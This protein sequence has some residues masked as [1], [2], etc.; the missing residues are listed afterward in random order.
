MKNLWK[1]LSVAIAAMSL[2][3]ACS[4]SNNSSIPTPAIPKRGVTRN[5][6]EKTQ[7]ASYIDWQ[8]YA[9]DDFYRYATGAWQDATDLGDRRSKGTQQKQDNAENEFP[10]KVCE[11]GCPLL[12]KLFTQ[13]KGAEDNNADRKKV[14]DKLADI[15][16]SVTTR[17]Q[18]WQK[19]AQLMK[20]GYAMPFDYC[21]ASN[22]RKI[23]P[24]LRAN[25]TVILAGENDLKQFASPEQTDL[26]VMPTSI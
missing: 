2:I 15:T 8:T 22:G 16:S 10:K 9:G 13:Y 12:Q 11:G 26:L 5:I 14:K 23:Y 21:A 3:A 19:I 1:N 20:E 25:E 7:Y 6:E 24:S 18:A 17:A 4:D